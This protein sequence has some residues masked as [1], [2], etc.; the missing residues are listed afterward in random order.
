[1][2]KIDLTDKA[3]YFCLREE[4]FKRISEYIGLSRETAI[5]LKD[6]FPKLYQF[7]FDESTDEL[8]QDKLRYLLIGPEQLPKSLGGDGEEKSLRGYLKNITR[9]YMLP[10]DAE[11]K[12][13]AK[14]CCRQ[15]FNYKK[16]IIDQKDAYWLLRTLNV[17]VCPYCNRM[18]T[19]TLPSPEEL[20]EDEKFQASRATFDHY[21]CQA[22][23]PHLALSLFN[24]VP[25][26]FSCNMNKKNL[27]EELV[28]PYEEE[29]GEEAV[30]RVIPDLEGVTAEESY[31]ILNFLHGESDQFQIRFMTKDGTA[32]Q[33]DAL[34]EDRLAGIEN[35]RLRKAICGS[36]VTFKLEEL[37]K[38]HAMEIRDI[39]RNRYYFDEQY[40]KTVVCPMLKQQIKL[41]ENK[42]KNEKELEKMVMDMLFFT[43]M[44]GSEWGKR[45][46]SK[47]VADILQQVTV[48]NCIDVYR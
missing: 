31:D 29:F 24:L 45:P 25:S 15:I 3:E 5:K 28:Y 26:C 1:M 19:V 38:E 47:L 30:F 18:Y 17:R 20:E 46:L 6:S 39:L 34:L 21:Y 4:Y 2:I 11:R 12:K 10:D 23:Y 22:E 8:K 33:K 36:V 14:E 44:D 42:T 32:L 27:A 35:E 16:F 13:Q 7:L 43:R 40:V 9:E 37:Y 48:D 41:R